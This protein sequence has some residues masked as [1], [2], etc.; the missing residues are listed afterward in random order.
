MSSGSGAGCWKFWTSWRM[1]P[2]K[3]MGVDVANIA[4]VK[5]VA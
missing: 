5:G 3:V 2:A 4:K 1:Q